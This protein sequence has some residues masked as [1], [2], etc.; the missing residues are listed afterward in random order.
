V[1]A[2]AWQVFLDRIPT[3]ENLCKMRIIQR[4]ETLCPSCGLGSE[5][6]CHLFLHCPFAAAV[7]YTLNR[8]LGVVVVLLG[9]VIMSYG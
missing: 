5:T 2:L 7:W 1:S 6:A 4:D 8:W 9:E 3:R